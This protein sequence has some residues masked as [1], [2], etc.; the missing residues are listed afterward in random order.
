M[1]KLGFLVIAMVLTVALFA[2]D[3][4]VL[5]QGVFRLT[6]LLYVNTYD[7]AFDEDFKSQDTNKATVA[8]YGVA[9]EYGLID[10]LSLGLQW[11]P[12]YNFYS[13]VKVYG[14]P[15]KK[16][17][18]APLAGVFAGAK[19]QLLG[20]QGIAKSNH[21]R[22]AVTAG[23]FIPVPYNA[24]D[25]ITNSLEGKDFVEPCDSVAF[26]IGARTDFDYIF[27]KFFDINVHTEFMRKLPVDADKDFAASY[28]NATV[29]A[30]IKEVDYGFYYFVQLF[31]KCE[32][33]LTNRISFNITTPLEY[34]Y[35]SETKWDGE[36]AI[37]D[38]YSCSAKLAP[39]IYVNFL[40]APLPFELEIDY[41]MNVAG[42]NVNNDKFF[43]ITFT[44]YF[45]F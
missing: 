23:G 18:I 40:D 3:G 5:P 30:G 44:P 28:N 33:N 42:R 11:T 35:T 22:F 26:M 32:V 8:G 25:Q 17:T 34:R 38:Y 9:L 19:F 1:K 7:K 12:A 39:G 6:N 36:K 41:E 21:M 37:D 2:D 14:D 24:E 43:S 4:E 27:P 15:N 29:G 20:E 31:P 10:C 45:S 13:D 16:V